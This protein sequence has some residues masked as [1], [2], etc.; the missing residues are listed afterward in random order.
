MKY[1]ILVGDGM[2][3]LPVPALGDRTPLEAA[4]IP[5]LDAVARHGV[6]GMY[7]PIPEGMPAGSEI[8]NLSLF[9]YDPRTTFCGRA[10]IEAASRRISLAADQVA[11]RCNLV[12]LEDG[13]MRDFTAGHITSEEGAA[14]IASLDAALSGAGSVRF[15]PGVSYRHLAVV[16]AGPGASVEDLVATDC[17][18][19]HNIMDQP[20]QAYWPQGPAASCVAEIMRQS[21]GVLAGH[22]VNARR[23]AA[24]KL[25]ATSA[26][27]WGQGTTPAMAP[28]R[29]KFGVSGAVVSAVDL[30]KGLGVL[31][32]LEVIDVPG[33]TGWIDTNYAGKVAA[34]MDALSRHDFV[35][36]HVEAPDEAAHQGRADLK[37]QAIEDFDAKV[38]APFLN[39]V[40]RTGEAR[41]LVAPDHF[42][43][44]STKGHYGDATPFALCGAGVEPIG[45]AAYSEKEAARTGIELREGYQLTERLFREDRIGF[46]V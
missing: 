32:G 18:P 17:T 45:V 33:A 35:Y 21:Q 12:T 22:E 40:E 16:T 2:A 19:P 25:T 44:L 23:A 13:V 7:W 6:V 15:H 36:V 4:H 43:L 29:E 27:L 41:L 11:F 37:I 24:G 10:P 3:D 5:A 8:G 14:I 20:H 38:V 1:I 31:A 9:G 46:R 34:A 42:T 26:W 28:Y 30:V 39:Y